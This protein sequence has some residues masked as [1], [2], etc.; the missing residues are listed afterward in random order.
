MS[1][2]PEGADLLKVARDALLADVRPLLG[3]DAKY[4][5]AM[6]A[7]AMAIAAREA[8]AGEAPALA[9]LARLD[10]LHGEPLRDLHGAALKEALAAHERRLAADIRAGRYDV[11]DARQRRLLQHLR[12]S[13]EAKLRISNPKALEG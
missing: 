6:I 10:R 7:N 5:A 11:N 8:Q 4:T 1:N 2:L 13:V 3:E 12:D 9:A